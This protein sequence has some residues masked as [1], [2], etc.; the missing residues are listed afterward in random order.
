MALLTIQLPWCFSPSE[1]PQ[2]YFVVQKSLIENSRLVLIKHFYGINQA[3]I[4]YLVESFDFLQFF[5]HKVVN[6][7]PPTHTVTLSG[8][9]NATFDLTEDMNPQSA[10][11]AFCNWNNLLFFHSK[12][13][14][15]NMQPQSY[16]LCGR[17]EACSWFDLQSIIQCISENNHPA[18]SN[19]TITITN[20][21]SLW[22]SGPLFMQLHPSELMQQSTEL[23]H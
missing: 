16:L 23:Y 2:K 3:V 4:R 13:H 6:P 10:I 7:Q 11:H 15:K 1:N 20:S 22:N 14:D 12:Q 17:G 9:L 21:N 8:A 18:I 19:R 5:I